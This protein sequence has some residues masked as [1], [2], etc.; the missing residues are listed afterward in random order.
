MHISKVKV[1]QFKNISSLTWLP[2]ARLNLITG[3]NGIGKTS[4]I[5]AIYTLCLTKSAFNLPEK[6]LVQWGNTFFVLEASLRGISESEDTTLISWHEEEKKSVRWN[7]KPYS[8]L[9]DHIGKLPI[10]LIQPY[11]S[12][13]IRLGAE[14][15]RKLFDQIFSQFDGEYLKSLQRYQLLIMSKS[16]VFQQFEISGKVDQDLLD[17]YDQ[18]LAYLN[19]TLSNKRFK[20]IDLLAPLL[21][22]NYKYLEGGLEK[23]GITYT[24]QV[25]NQDAKASLAYSRKQDITAGRCTWGIHRDDYE[26]LFDKELLRKVGSQGQQKTYGIALK[27]ALYALLSD[28]TQKK[29]LLLLDDVFDKLDDKRITR[30]IDRV[31]QSHF[32]QVFITDAR[33]ERSRELLSLTTTSK[34]YL[35]LE[36]PEGKS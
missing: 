11:D 14:L 32:G 25:I 17:V 26:F 29:P 23:V 22:D 12:D 6:S 35:E 2:D 30:L 19:E 9:A 36:P 28:H 24:S 21:K 27:L 13:T 31:S 1:T 4:L 10:V 16:K 33:P 5:D 3:I 8:R 15:R 18:E 34:G 7:G 20:N